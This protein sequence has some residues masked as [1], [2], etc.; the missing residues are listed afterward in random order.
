MDVGKATFAEVKGVDRRSAPNARHSA[1]PWKVDKSRPELRRHD[2]SAKR[3][4][5][6]P[7]SGRGALMLWFALQTE[8]DAPQLPGT[9]TR[10]L[11][12]AR[13]AREAQSLPP[14]VGSTRCA[15][16]KN[17][18]LSL[19]LSL[20]PPPSAALYFVLSSRGNH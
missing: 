13:Y 2:H 8:Q 4:G 14:P 7:T 10:P 15:Q 11:I 9:T 3:S 1:A 5:L 19:A 16:A 20:R 6:Q 17:C 12:V 18:L